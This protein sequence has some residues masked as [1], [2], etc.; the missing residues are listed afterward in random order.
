[1]GKTVEQL[2]AADELIRWILSRI[3]HSLYV[4]IAPKSIA[5][6][7]CLKYMGKKQH[8]VKGK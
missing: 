1:M 5:H 6:D 4:D 7:L 2:E 8:N 3:D